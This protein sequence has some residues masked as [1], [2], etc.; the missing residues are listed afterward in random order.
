MHMSY[1]GAGL[2]LVSLV[3]GCSDKAVPVAVIPPP[4]AAPVAVTPAASKDALMQAVFGKQY[5]PATKDAL[6][7]LPMFEDRKKIRLFIVEPL[8]TTV[9]AT[10][11]TVLVAKSSY[12]EENEEKIEQPDFLNIYSSVYLLREVAGKWTVVKRHPNIAYRGFDERRGSVLFPMLG[13]DMPGLA[14]ASGTNDEG[15]FSNAIHLFDLRDDPLRDLTGTGIPTGSST[16]KSCGGT[17]L[18]PNDETNAS[19]YL[20][21]PK[22]PSAYSDIVMTFITEIT[23]MSSAEENAKKSVISKKNSA[24]YAYDGKL[25]KLVTGDSPI[26]DLRPD[27][28][29]YTN[30]APSN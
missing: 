27:G 29:P 12:A 20:A 2:L 21:P 16:T 4:A 6:T 26:D 14:L 28:K 23:I 5:R 15:C 3:A 25:Y 13:K 10:G 18:K 11:V 30:D 24:R 8:A 1:F 17:D 9:L 7:E 19:W 22:K